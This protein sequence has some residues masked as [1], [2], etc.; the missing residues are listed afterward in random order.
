M[1]RREIFQFTFIS[2]SFIWNECFKSSFSFCVSKKKEEKKK[3]RKC[4][5]W[6]KNEM[7]I[8]GFFIFFQLKKKVLQLF[9][10]SYFISYFILTHMAFLFSISYPHVIIIIIYINIHFAWCFFF[11]LLLNYDEIFYTI[12]IFIKFTY[13]LKAM[14]MRKCYLLI[15]KRKE[16]H[17]ISWF[18][19]RAIIINNNY[20]KNERK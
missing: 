12:Y 8:F 9:H 11:L 14:K 3:K 19:S 18:K 2:S 10:I 16:S 1:K 20:K 13:K 17:E 5:I 4:L 6:N 15:R 7:I